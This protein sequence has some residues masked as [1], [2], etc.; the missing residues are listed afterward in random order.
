[1]AGAEKF[2]VGDLVQ[3]K[4]GGPIMTVE[5]VYSTDSVGC[6]W[7]AGAKLNSGHFDPGALLPA[8][9]AKTTTK[10]D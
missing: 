6:H 3:L 1:M 5:T 2:K 7:F 10:K 9:P 8:E 4:S